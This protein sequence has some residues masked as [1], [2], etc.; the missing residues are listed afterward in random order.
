[1]N[2]S[3]VYSTRQTQ[4]QA[5]TFSGGLETNLSKIASFGYDGVE[6]AIRD[7]SQ[8][9]IDE[10]EK[11][12][13]KN[14]LIV[15]AI[16]TGQAWGEEGLSF[17]DPDPE[18]RTV[19]VERIRSHIPVAERFQA[20][21]IIGLIRGILK[22]G[23]S[24]PQAMEWMYEALRSCSQA[25]KTLG[26][27]LALEP[28]NRYETSLINYVQQGLDLI[29]EVREDN[30]GLLLDTFHMNI[31]EP[32]IEESI[33]ACGDRIFHFHVADSNRWHPGAGHLNFESVLKALHVTGYQGFVSGEFLAH[34]DA[35][36]AAQKSINYLKPIINKIIRLQ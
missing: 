27:R 7:P 23:V 13:Q 11:L 33:R 35:D 20:V 8:V 29:K 26:V 12:V 32:S 1:M 9:N 30:F 2:L 5:A 6:L 36:T 14:N 34:P 21:I 22:P 4:F 31:E 19:A 10:L 28:I 24:H 17:T 16:G 18:V 3:I 25:A 15:P